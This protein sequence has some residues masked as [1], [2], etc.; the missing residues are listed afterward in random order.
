MD[1][2][3][4]RV[5]L[6]GAGPG[7]PGLITRLGADAL[8][9]A[10]VVVHDHLVH[11]R[12]LDLAPGSCRRIFA[13]KRGGKPSMPQ[14]EIQRILL[15]EARQGRRVVRLKGGDPFVFGRGAE[16]L[17]FLRA[18]GV[19]C[20]V[21]PGVTAGVG[22]T[23][24]AGIPV[25]HRDASSAVAFVTGHQAP[26]SSTCRL[27]WDGL[28][29]FPGTLVVYMGLTHLKAICESLIAAG[30]PPA[31]P[32][33]IVQSGTVAS[34]KTAE[35]TLLDLPRIAEVASIRP[36]ALLVVGEVVGRRP[37]MNWFEG[38]PLFGRR[39]AATRSRISTG[40]TTSMAGS[41]RWGASVIRGAPGDGRA[42]RYALA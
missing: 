32:A 16:E 8:A 31:T 19:D 40:P 39:I 21:I 22:V 20:R 42:D 34:Q 10:E 38:L 1:D 30:K 33:A 26:G 17:E 24:Y 28:A 23:A 41:N 37:S 2:R 6:V 9:R 29:R 11:P 35:G 12:L 25:T 13:G 15:E 7:D 18:H 14:D 36:P 27:D 3:S 4:G 5:T